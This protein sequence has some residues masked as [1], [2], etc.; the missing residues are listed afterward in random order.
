MGTDSWG[1]NDSWAAHLRDQIATPVLPPQ[2]K[3]KYPGKKKS[4]RSR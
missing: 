3:V 2:K 4:K 1:Q